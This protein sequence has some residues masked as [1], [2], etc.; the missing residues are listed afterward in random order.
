MNTRD[1]IVIQEER[2]RQE[3]GHRLASGYREFHH[4]GQENIEN[5]EEREQGP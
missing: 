2:R 4:R 3:A 5:T 1:F